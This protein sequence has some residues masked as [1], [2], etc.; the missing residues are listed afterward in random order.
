[1]RSRALAARG[2]LALLVA[3]VTLLALSG[4]SPTPAR[5]FTVTGYAEAGATTESQLTASRSA[6]T[7]VGVDGVN[8]TADGAGVTAPNAAAL[9][10]L[11]QAHK[12]HKKASLLFGN[13]SDTIY[14][15]SD[16]IA[17]KM[18]G[19]SDNIHAVVADLVGEVDSG[20]WDGVTVDLES[21]NG[22]GEQGHTRDDNAG[23]D[24][25]VTALRKALGKRT[26]SICLSATT[27]SYEDLGY[28]LGTISK[29]VDDVVLM[30]YDQHGPAWSSAGPVGGYPWVKQSVAGL[31][32]GVP[33]AKI[34]LGIGEY[35]YSWPTSGKGT[36]Y[37]V[38]AMRALVKS[39]G[40]TPIWSA[41][42]KEWHATL[43][44]GTV[45]WWSDDRSYQSRLALARKLGL[46]GVAVW[47]LGQSDPL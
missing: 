14:D 35:G 10:L 25:F 46:A 5:A 18:F 37:T 17:E 7:E 39:G 22:F 28:D 32:K 23:L 29:Q 33:A 24:A 45:V 19:S 26:L 38:A 4:C 43:S 15:F 21:L 13:Y 44:N 41:S 30:A 9:A 31:R 6:L 47:S 36:V 42:Q 1:M 16:S 12:L 27:A 3:G 34:Q 20:G 2:A 8:L 40:G 11:A